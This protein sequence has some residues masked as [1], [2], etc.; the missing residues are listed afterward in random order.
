ML[1]VVLI[2]KNP[3]K[4]TISITYGN[5]KFLIHE[6]RKMAFPTKSTRANL[7]LTA[8][9]E[10]GHANRYYAAGGKYIR[11][12]NINGC[13]G[14]SCCNTYR[15]CYSAINEGQADFHGYLIDNRTISRT[16]SYLEARCESRYGITL[17]STAT[18]IYSK[19]DKSLRHPKGQIH[20]MGL[21][22]YT[23]IWTQIYNHPNVNKKYIAVLFS[24]HLPLLEANDDFVTVGV[25]IA[26]LANQ[27]DE[28]PRYAEIIRTIFRDRGLP[29]DGGGGVR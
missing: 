7:F 25:K 24:E 1:Y 16:S 6:L 26:N 11:S 12:L 22:V 5:S 14:N 21:L 29:L 18:D 15:G 19:C 10:A 23:T 20:T 4:I 9:H 28:G 17:T 3:N 13:S 27:F 2:P 8:F